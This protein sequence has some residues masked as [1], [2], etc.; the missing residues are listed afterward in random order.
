M[1]RCLKPGGK[2]L[3]EV[4][5]K[6]NFD[7]FWEIINGVGFNFLGYDESLATAVSHL[8]PP[9]DIGDVIQY[10]FKP[11]SGEPLSMPLRLFSAAELR[12]ELHDVGLAQDKR[13]G[14]HVLINLIPSTILHKSDPGRLLRVAFGGLASIEKLVNSFWSLNVFG[15]SLLVLAHKQ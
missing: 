13:W 14:L 6:W 4:E 1:A 3:L 2:L 12:R 10:S 9:W 7:L 5:G 15:C 8:R 11:E